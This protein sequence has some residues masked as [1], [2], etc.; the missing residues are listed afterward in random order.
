MNTTPQTSTRPEQTQNKDE[1]YRAKVNLE[2]ARIA[3]R[4]LQRFFASGA[5]IYVSGDL[6]LVEVAFQLSADNKN[7]VKTWM[8]AGQ[9]APVNDKQALAWFEADADMWAVVV[10]PF[11]LVQTA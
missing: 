10:S 6:D 7:Q 8:D 2:T 1:I 11:V 5:A 4:E 9:V 3:W